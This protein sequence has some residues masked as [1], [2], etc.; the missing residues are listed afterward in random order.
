MREALRPGSAGGL[1]RC[2]LRSLSRSRLPKEEPKKAERKRTTH[3]FDG[4]SVHGVNLASPGHICGPSLTCAHTPGCRP[5]IVAGMVS[6]P[7]GGRRM[8][9]H[10]T[11]IS[12]SWLNA[13]EGLV[14][15]ARTTRGP[16][17]CLTS[18][19]GDASC[20]DSLRLTT[21]GPPSPL[22]QPD[23]HG[24]AR[25]DLGSDGACTGLV[26]RFLTPRSRPPLSPSRQRESLSPDQARSRR[27]PL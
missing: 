9:L 11:S 19:Q 5:R 12:A 10:F 18:V 23:P 15:P 13:V 6:A 7:H 25:L 2:V 22:S 3:M 8:H 24:L 1:L 20:V 27:L 21:R 17:R 16:T 14:L 4:V 26:R